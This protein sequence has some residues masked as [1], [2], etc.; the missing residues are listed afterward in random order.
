[1]IPT[2]KS[3]HKIHR[4]LDHERRQPELALEAMKRG[5]ALHHVGA[6]DWRLSTGQHVSVRV[7]NIIKFNRNVVGVGDS[8]FGVAARELSQTWRWAG[9]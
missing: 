1:V 5:P 4:R 9:D 3:L 2:P 8:L 6:G 7:A